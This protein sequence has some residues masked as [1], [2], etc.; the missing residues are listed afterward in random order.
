MSRTLSVWL[1]KLLLVAVACTSHAAFAAYGDCSGPLPLTVNLPSVNVPASLA[2]GQTIPGA[3]ASFAVP[4]T[5]TV[6]PVNDWYL[7]L[8]SGRA[9]LVSGFTDVYTTSGM[10]PGIGFRIRS[11]AGTVLEPFN[12]GAGS[13]VDIGPS[14]LGANV[15]RGTFE[16]VKTGTPAAGSGGFTAFGTV[17]FKEYANGANVPNSTINFN[18]TVLSTSIPSCSVTTTAVAVSMPYENTSVFQA[19]GMTAGNASFNL[20]LTCD[21]NANPSISFMDSA[22]PTNQTNTLTLAP[23]STAT[24]VGVQILYQ[25]APVTF[26]PGTYSYTT[27]NTPSINS[28]ALGT[29]SGTQSV[30]LQARYVQTDSSVTPGLIRAVATFTMNY[31]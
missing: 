22:T 14:Q 28:V 23:G 21:A 2:V 4:L 6:N 16:L 29:L 24:G 17:D 18:Y 9:T 25:A 3:T 12:Y 13:A 31:N 30:P 7:A 5:C 1:K 26:S 27:S 8:N 20:S 19:V 10:T 11:T 15:L